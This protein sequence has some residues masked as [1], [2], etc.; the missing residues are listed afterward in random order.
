MKTKELGWVYVLSNPSFDQDLIKVGMSQNDPALRSEELRTTGVPTPFKVEYKALVAD[1][2]EVEKRVH[3]DLNRY[4]N[5]DDREFFRCPVPMAI[6]SIKKIADIRYEDSEYA[7]PHTPSE[8]ELQLQAEIDAIDREEAEQLAEE[9]K[10]E[11]ERQLAEDIKG[12]IR[13]ARV[14]ENQKVI[15]QEE[16]SHR[17][18]L[19]ASG[20]PVFFI[21]LFALLDRVELAIWCMWMIPYFFYQ[22]TKKYEAKFTAEEARLIDALNNYS[23]S[24]EELIKVAEGEN[25]VSVIAK[26]RNY[27]E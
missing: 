24:D 17:A 3:A 10:I 9:K 11:Q 22:S 13:D 26:S 15:E 20:G 7:P 8:R 5:T 27:L 18:L 19:I 21:G 2:A 4:R 23:L 6:Q 1:H 12:K 16:K 14:R 25:P